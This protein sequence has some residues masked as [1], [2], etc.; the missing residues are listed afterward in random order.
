MGCALLVPVVM[1]AAA[2]VWCGASALVEH[3]GFVA[4]L[5]RQNPIPAVSLLHHLSKR[6]RVQVIIP[7]LWGLFV[8]IIRLLAASFVHNG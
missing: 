4:A 6:G 3:T 8:A 7:L 2:V 1:A 5:E